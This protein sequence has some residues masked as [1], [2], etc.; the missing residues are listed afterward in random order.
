MY[1][2]VLFVP[3]VLMYL[4]YLLSVKKKTTCLFNILR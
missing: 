1:A 4:E 2:Y 3:L